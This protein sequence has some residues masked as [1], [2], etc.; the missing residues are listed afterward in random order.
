MTIAWLSIPVVTNL[1]SGHQVMNTSFDPLDLVNTYGAF[2]S[3]GK[4]RRE[5]VFA[6]TAGAASSPESAW[7]EYPFR[8]APGDPVRR[9]CVITP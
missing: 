4:E 5:L 6:G 3:V 8:C 1:L 2:G 9:P 7:R